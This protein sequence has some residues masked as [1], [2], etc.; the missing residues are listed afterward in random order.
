MQLAV[1]REIVIADQLDLHLIW[2]E[3]GR[4]FLKPIPT[5][6]LDSGLWIDHLGSHDACTSQIRRAGSCSCNLELRKVALGFLYTYVCLIASETDFKI[7]KDKGLLPLEGFVLQWADWKLL[8]RS[9][10]ECYEPAKVHPRFHRAELRLSRLNFI[11]L[12]LNPLSFRSYFGNWNNYG[13]FYRDNIAWMATTTVFIALILT[14]MQLGIATDR[15]QG[16]RAF[17]QA[18]YGFTI[19]SIFAPLSV[20]VLVLLVALLNL[21]HDLPKIRQ[22]EKGGKA[23]FQIG[24]QP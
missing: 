24:A 4:I 23:G 7:A 1:G 3:R 10:L 11:S 16:S 22:R 2:D 20:M 8:A 14:A 21:M 9:L 13:S 17:Q 18:S 6:L 19:F 12:L 15:L 5:F